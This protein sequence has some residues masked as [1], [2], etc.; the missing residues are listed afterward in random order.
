MKRVQNL[1][2]VFTFQEMK[3]SQNSH[4]NNISKIIDLRFSHLDDLIELNF[5]GF[6][7]ETSPEY[8]YNLIS[9]E[10]QSTLV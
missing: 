4:T 2:T 5:V 10:K 8:V 7:H 9:L 3:Y 1:F 6:S